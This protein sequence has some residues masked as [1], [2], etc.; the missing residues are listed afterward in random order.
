M[1]KKK[2]TKHEEQELR[3]QPHSSDAEKAILGSILVNE[4]AFD[5]AAQYILSLIHI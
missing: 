1:A 5:V 2:F 3:P 4:E